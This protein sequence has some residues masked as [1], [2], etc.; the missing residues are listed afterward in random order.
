MILALMISEL[1]IND[2]VNKDLVGKN[3][4]TYL[5]HAIHLDELG[6]SVLVEDYSFRLRLRVSAKILF[7]EIKF[8]NQNQTKFASRPNQMYVQEDQPKINWRVNQP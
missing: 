6:N 2:L 4:D 8:P 7:R 3:M 5:S 1:D